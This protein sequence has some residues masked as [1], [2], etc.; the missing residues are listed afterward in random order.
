MTEPMQPKVRRRRSRATATLN[1]LI[2]TRITAGLITIL[3][4]IITVLLIRVVFGWLR[5]ASLWIVDAFL[6]SSWGRGVVERWGLT[7]AQLTEAGLQGLPAELQWGISLFCVALTV[8]LLYLIGLFAANV[9]GR[10]ALELIDLIAGRVPFVK[11]IYS[12]LKQILALFSGESTQRFQR[13][14]L[15]P[16]PNQLTRSVGF[17]TNT[18]QDATTGEELCAV[19]IATTPNPTTGFV[20]VVRRADITEVDWS[21]EDAVKIIMSGGI[22]APS[23]VTMSTGTVRTTAGPPLPRRAPDAPRA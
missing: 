13:V 11:T 23:D 19:F 17:I 16:F 18:M 1:A 9:L 22:L 2:R 10:R 20:F 4:I 15:V 12:A 14:A 6:L 5:D 21:I 7:P 3:P 8:I